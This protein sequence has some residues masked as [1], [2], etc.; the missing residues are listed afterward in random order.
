[1]ILPDGHHYRLR[2]YFE[3]TD[4]GGVVYH[5]GYLRFA[6]RG[7]TEALRELGAP[8]AE[9]AAQHGLVFMVRRIEV[10]YLG[11]A[12][13]DDSLDVV[14]RLVALG[15]SRVDLMQEVRR[16]AGVAARLMVGLACVRVADLRPLRVPPRWRAAIAALGA[17]G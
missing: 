4:A 14:T 11:A 7:R 12:R 15:A 16:D 3:D 9:M 5:A 8:H 6:E 10:D 17:P 1:M 2:V 13:R